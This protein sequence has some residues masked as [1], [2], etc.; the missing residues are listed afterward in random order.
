MRCAV[1]SVEQQA[2]C[3]H[4][5][6]AL[7]VRQHT[8]VANSLRALSEIGIVAAQGIEGCAS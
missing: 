5:T 6:R 7:L 1:K 3:C 2:T 4:T 8:M